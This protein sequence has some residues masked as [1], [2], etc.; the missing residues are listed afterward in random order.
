MCMLFNVNWKSANYIKKN[1]KI[2]V[3][4]KPIL[5]MYALP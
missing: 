3:D 5:R 1:Y 4:K 2:N